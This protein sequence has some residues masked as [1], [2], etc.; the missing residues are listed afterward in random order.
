[1]GAFFAG[2]WSSIST[3]FVQ[4]W[5]TTIT[6]LTSINI[7]TSI[8]DVIAVTLL[9]YFVLILIRDSRA[10]HLVKGVVFFLVVYFVAKVFHLQALSYII[11]I[12][13]GNALIILVVIFQPELRKALEHAGHTRLG[14][15]ILR[16]GSSSSD[17]ALE[18]QRL[19]ETIDAIC[20]G[21]EKLQE[22]KMGALVVFE[23]DTPLDGI[24]HSGTV[25][26]ANPTAELV[27]NI[28][29][30]KSA[31]HDGAM[32]IRDCRIHYAGC[33]LPLTERRNM[34]SQFGT[35]HRAGLGLSEQSDAFV[36]ILSEETGDISLAISGMLKEGYTEETLRDALRKELLF[37]ITE[38]NMKSIFQRRTKNHE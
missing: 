8:I 19:E 20:D 6:F 7:V 37:G 1:M 30:D 38:I 4:L 25:I 5:D 32:V 35:R 12:F 13:L 11:D 29:F 33:I 2:I 26:D 28:F 34:N 17:E 18:K 22:N 16:F 3:F 14:K 15:T 27:E 31:L 24:V 23:R 10:K 9:F 36:I 21:I